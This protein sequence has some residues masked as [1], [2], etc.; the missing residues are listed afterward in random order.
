M[1]IATSRA[2]ITGALLMP[3]LLLA[4]PAQAQYFRGAL[5]GANEVPPNGS[6]ALGNAIV[7]LDGTQLTIDCRGKDV[8]ATV[9]AGKFYKRKA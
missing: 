2:L 9:V 5:S 4:A 6:T 1:R 8:A 3:A 7:Y